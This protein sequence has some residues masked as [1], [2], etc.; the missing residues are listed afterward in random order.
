VTEARTARLAGRVLLV[1]EDERVLLFRGADPGRPGHA[2]WFTPGGGLEPGETTAAGAAREL[3][4]ET[5]LAVAPEALGE[6]VWRETTEFP[7]DGVWYRQWQEF[8]LL[9][10][11]RWEVDTTGFNTVERA[12]VDAHRW[13]TVDELRGTPERVYPVDLAALLR[14]ALDG[15]ATAGPADGPAPSEAELALG[16]RG[17]LDGAGPVEP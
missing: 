6:P 14:R 8:F 1:D 2:Y 4:E 3:R 12:T 7:F 17:P 15:G 13:W 9:R 5:G 10:V 11:A 16:R